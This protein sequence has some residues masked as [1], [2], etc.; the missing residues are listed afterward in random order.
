M[1]KR[2]WEGM[3]GAG[4][5]NGGEGLVGGVSRGGWKVRNVI[6]DEDLSEVCE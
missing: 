2:V 5:C 4:I 1:V 3:G 6:G